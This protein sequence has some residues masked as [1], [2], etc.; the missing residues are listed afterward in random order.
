VSFRVG[1]VRTEQMKNQSMLLPLFHDDGNSLAVP[2]AEAVAL[3][4]PPLRDLPNPK[5]Q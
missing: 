5:A 1:E 3:E 2:G 4:V